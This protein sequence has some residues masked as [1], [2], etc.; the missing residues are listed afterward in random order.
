MKT[1][2]TLLAFA[3]LL[4]IGISFAKHVPVE[5]AQ[6]IGKNFFYERAKLSKYV[7][8][9]NISLSLLTMNKTTDP[10]FYIF[11]V[12]DN[13]GYVIISADDLV[14]P[15][16]AYSIEQPFNLEKTPAPVTMMLEGYG[17]V[18]QEAKSGKAVSDDEIR[19]V[20]G[21]F[22]Y[23]SPQ[24]ATK[25]TTALVSPLLLTKWDQ[26][27]P[28]NI[29]CPVDAAGDGGH[30]YVGCVAVAM[31][32]V[33][34]YYNFPTT[35]TGSYTHYSFAN[36]GYGNITINF[37]NQTYDWSAMPF[38]TAGTSYFDEM[39]KLMYHLGVACKMS[40]S[41]DGSSSN[42]SNAYNG[43]KNYY[44]YDPSIALVYKTSYTDASW[45]T[46]LKNSLNAKRPLIYVGRPVSGAGHAW[47][48][49]GYDDAS[50]E[51]MF[52]MNWGWGGYNDGFYLLTNLYAPASP[53]QPASSLME[54][55]Q[56]IHNIFP[57]T[58]LA[59]PNNY[60]LNCTT[61][62]TFTNIEGNFEDGSG[63]NDYQNNQT[64]TYL[65]NP[66][67]G[68][69]V[70]L[71]FDA[72]DVEASDALYIYDGDSD[73][74]SLIAVYHGGDTPE[75]HN[76]SGKNVFLKFIT[77]GSGTA[78]GWVARYAIDYCKSSLAF[79]T[80]SGTFS[81]G[82]GPCE[83]KK[84]TNCTW[85]IN[86]P[87]ATSININFTEFALA[88][89]ADFL[90]V[91]KNEISTANL[92]Q[93]FTYLNVPSGTITVP[94]GISTLRF[95]TNTS[96]S[97]QGW[98]LNYNAIVSDVNNLS[99]PTSEVYVYPNPFN[100]DAVISYDIN[101]SGKVRLSISNV[102]GQE[103]YVREK[104]TPAGHY[105]NSIKSLIPSLKQGIYLIKLESE[106]KSVVK[107]LVYTK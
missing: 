99:E 11:N 26:G 57:P 15:I 66:T 95:F 79:T 70:R 103:I 43:L 18:I 56:V 55:Q 93:K 7:V 100:E 32:Q 71:Y 86:V 84:S 34:K 36:G 44:R 97:T 10:D 63:H 31:A 73:T 69:Y 76:A 54:D 105:E 89:D 17:R 72:F 22:D 77:N 51:D 58:T 13:Q 98:A 48:C 87:G 45:K 65:I 14:R 16:L 91:Y 60:P 88:S 52:H 102:I 94:A 90:S 25:E 35:G 27:S 106:G 80:Q 19:S 107:R 4:T 96:L 38:T 82:S 24:K 75:M 28:F 37:A 46:L 61:S 33:V 59:A 30:V 50:G 12:N 101:V 53:G 21:R 20:W 68:A 39:A 6:K 104:N 3:F 9:N 49:D 62:R 81:D 85:S 29:A 83:Y 5:Y 40:W 74:D 2:I 64:C 42:A 41:A 78:P 8:Y 1:K 23:N 67:C 92:I 47:N